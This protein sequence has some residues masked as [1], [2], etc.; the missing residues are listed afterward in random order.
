MGS[1]EH[2]STC[3]NCVDCGAST[4][5]LLWLAVPVD[6][7]GDH[8]GD[9]LRRLQH[10]DVADAVELDHLRGVGHVLEEVEMAT[11][12][13]EHPGRGSRDAGGAATR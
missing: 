10:R 12:R 7:V 5:G 2:G 4:D 9:A 6:E 11:R 1:P 3:E 8:R 13:G